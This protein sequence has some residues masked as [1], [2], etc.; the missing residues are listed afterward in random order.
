M[1]AEDGDDAHSQEVPRAGYAKWWRIAK[2]GALVAAGIGV[3]LL[4]TILP[5]GWPILLAGLG[6][7][8]SYFAWARWLR[9]KILKLLPEK[10]RQYIEKYL[11]KKKQ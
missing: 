3:I 2:G 10:L 5:I 4:P 9:R 6:I 7:L 8:A 1:G 11:G